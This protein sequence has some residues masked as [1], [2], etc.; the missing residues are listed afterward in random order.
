MYYYLH[1]LFVCGLCM[2]NV[3]WA[4]P[5]WGVRDITNTIVL[6]AKAVRRVSEAHVS[7]SYHLMGAMLSDGSHVPVSLKFP[8]A[9]SM[10][11][12]VIA[13]SVEESV[14]SIA[15]VCVHCVHDHS[16]VKID[17]CVFA[18]NATMIWIDPVST[19]DSNV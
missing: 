1:V 16:E 10:L 12:G 5:R 6:R 17:E 13:A 19:N 9:S 3:M 4:V 2:C 15:F 18:E 14:A 7:F 11:V 8:L